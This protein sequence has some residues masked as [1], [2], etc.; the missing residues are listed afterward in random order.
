MAAMETGTGWTQEQIDFYECTLCG[1]TAKQH[2]A[3]NCPACKYV[4][5]SFEVIRWPKPR[6]AV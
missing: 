4:W 5:D 1:Y 3:D 6:H 2:E